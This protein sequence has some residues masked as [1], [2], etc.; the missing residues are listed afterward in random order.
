VCERQHGELYVYHGVLSMS[1]S[2]SKTLCCYS[3]RHLLL[4][5][6][7]QHVFLCVVNCSAY[8]CVCV[9]VVIM[10][11][12]SACWLLSRNSRYERVDIIVL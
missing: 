8:V 7:L 3:L 6:I 10:C 12:S 4:L 1:M 11:G 5:E 9:F 2:S